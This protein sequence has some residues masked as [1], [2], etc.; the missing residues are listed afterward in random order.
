ML[1]KLWLT[2]KV[3]LNFI[4]ML[5]ES[6]FYLLVDILFKSIFMSLVLWIVLIPISEYFKFDTPSLKV[7]FAI[8]I[9]IRVVFI[10]K[11]DTF[12]MLDEKGK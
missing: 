9:A 10:V 4:K 3:N 6:F 1:K 5:I 7:V 11:N 8:L 12:F 2:V